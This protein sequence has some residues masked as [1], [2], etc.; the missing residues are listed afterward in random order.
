[1]SVDT[2]TPSHIIVQQSITTI[3]PGI[4]VLPTEMSINK[5]LIVSIARME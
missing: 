3:D 5:I 2:E 4:I 1:M